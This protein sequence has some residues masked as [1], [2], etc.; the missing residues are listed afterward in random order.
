MNMAPFCVW[1]TLLSRR[2]G[3]GGGRGSDVTHNYAQRGLIL[4]PSFTQCVIRVGELLI[5]CL[6]QIET[7]KFRI[8]FFWFRACVGC[9]MDGHWPEVVA[10]SNIIDNFN[11]NI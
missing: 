4:F 11:F 7:N 2:E 1:V 10:A 3:K 9:V 5:D 8:F 6:H